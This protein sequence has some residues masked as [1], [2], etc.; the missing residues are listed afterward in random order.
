MERN[1]VF[2]KIKSAEEAI[3]AYKVQQYIKFANGRLPAQE[4]VDDM[5]VHAKTLG[6]LKESLALGPSGSLCP[7]CGGSGRA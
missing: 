3:S 2:A 4:R 6:L 5:E 1:E 7:K